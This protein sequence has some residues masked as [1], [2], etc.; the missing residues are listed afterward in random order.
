MYVKTWR[1]RARISMTSDCHISA[2]LTNVSYFT[3]FGGF[4]PL[5]SLVT[6]FPLCSALGRFLQVK[7]RGQCVF[8]LSFASFGRDGWRHASGRSASRDQNNKPACSSTSVQIAL[9]IILHADWLALYNLTKSSIDLV[10]SMYVA[11]LEQVLWMHV[12]NQLICRCHVTSRSLYT[13]QQLCVGSKTAIIFS[14]G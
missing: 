11:R 13:A 7:W 9:L 4:S 14:I 6:L 8:L 5:V 2:R 12:T 10:M 3:Q 1:C